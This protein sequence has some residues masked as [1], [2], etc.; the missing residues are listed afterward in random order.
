MIHI[1]GLS[2][3]FLMIIFGFTMLGE[4]PLVICGLFTYRSGGHNFRVVFYFRVTGGEL[5]LCSSFHT[6]SSWKSMEKKDSEKIFYCGICVRNS[7][8]HAGSRCSG[9]TPWS[10]AH[11]DHCIDWPFFCSYPILAKERRERLERRHWRFKTVLAVDCCDT[12][13]QIRR[14]RNP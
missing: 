7:L 9:R 13:Q 12:S 8:C 2:K 3:Y 1:L 10:S 11:V 14:C 4:D 6:P 5:C